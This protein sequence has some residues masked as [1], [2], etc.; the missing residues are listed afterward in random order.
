MFFV[1]LDQILANIIALILFYA[2]EHRL[3]KCLFWRFRPAKSG[4]L[5]YKDKQEIQRPSR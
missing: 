3:F 1:S 4:A 5:N 2:Q